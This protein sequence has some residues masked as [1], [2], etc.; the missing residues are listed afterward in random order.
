MHPRTEHLLTLRD[1][2]PVAVDV[3]EHV[4]GCMQCRTRLEE[5][6]T[7]QWRLQSLP[8]VADSSTRG[9]DDVKARIA[10][11]ARST[12]RR[13]AATRVAAA[14]S[15]VVI[16]V[17]L[18]WRYAGNTSP[19]YLAQRTL[20]PYTAFDSLALDRV[21]EL[22]SESQELDELLV[23]LGQ[24][25]AVERAG[26]AVPIESLE[27]QVQWVDHQLSS[28][29]DEIAAQSAERLW[30]ERVDLMHSLVRLRYVEAQAIAM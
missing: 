25:P 7:M 4:A 26:S 22:Q 20:K 5:F 28:G 1:G 15:V 24:R 10:G 6:E 2:G 11:R 23:A 29:G 19:E 9:W 16:A 14:A 12:Q 27:A 21:S 13:V 18:V 8:L 3:R 17:A 30:R